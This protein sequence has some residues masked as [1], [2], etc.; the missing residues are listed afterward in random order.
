MCI[1]TKNKRLQKYKWYKK[2]NKI[3]KLVMNKYYALCDIRGINIM[4]C[5][6]FEK[7]ISVVVPCMV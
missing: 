5:V 3:Q 1:K 7:T 4:L 2:Q 6:I